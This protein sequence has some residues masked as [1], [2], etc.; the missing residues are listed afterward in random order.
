[1]SIADE[2]PLNR[3]VAI[4]S[5]VNREQL[6]TEVRE[7]LGKTGFYLSDNINT[8]GMSFDVIGRRDQ[9]LLLIKVLLNV[10]AF[11]EKNA[12]ELKLIAKTLGGSPIL[13]GQKSGGGRLE[14]GVIYSRFGVPILSKETFVDFFTEGVPPYVF[15]APGG[16]YVRLDG[17]FL[18]RLRDQKNI[19]LGT[20][21]EVAGV[22]RRTVQMYLEGMSA[23]ID[24]ALRLEEFFGEPLVVPVDPFVYTKGVE[25][26]L[27]S[28]GDFDAFEK[29]I[30]HKLKSLGYSILP[31]VKCP[32]EAL[33]RDADSLFLT[34]V[35]GRN[36][37]VEQK[38]AIV[39]SISR[40]AERDSVIFVEK[41]GVRM[42]I[43]GTPLI[44][45]EELKRIK[46]REEIEDLI[47][48]RKK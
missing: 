32:F 43:K 39:S 11:T 3:S 21:A 15:S 22:S 6:I 4:F 37:N 40:V 23:T 45:K 41:T 2:T 9:N 13:I 46:E 42:S 19:S 33:T 31:T 8:R 26:A 18:R 14:E 7:V 38:V 5:L 17:D 16:L 36:E 12:N 1:V 28:W 47:K 20:L 48:E 27:A 35:R 44:G 34:G 30:F 25:E 10:D 24:I 29:H